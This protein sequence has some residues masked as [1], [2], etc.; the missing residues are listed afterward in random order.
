MYFVFR[1]FGGILSRGKEIKGAAGKENLD[2]PEE[3]KVIYMF[4]ECRSSSC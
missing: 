2:M 1:I 3:F 4:R